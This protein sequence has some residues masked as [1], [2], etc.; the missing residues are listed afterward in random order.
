[1]TNVFF[2]TGIPFASGWLFSDI[3]HSVWQP[4][5]LVDFSVLDDGMPHKQHSRSESLRVVELQ[6][7]ENF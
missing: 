7:D 4:A 6:I 3:N 2:R 1:M 5:W